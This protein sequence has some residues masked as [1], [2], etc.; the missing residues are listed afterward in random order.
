MFAYLTYV[1]TTYAYHFEK[2][3]FFLSFIDCLMFIDVFFFQ[4]IK[5][6]KFNIFSYN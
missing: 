6:C 3:S 1:I 4:P 2:Y 5:N